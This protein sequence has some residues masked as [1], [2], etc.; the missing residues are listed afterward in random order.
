MTSEK[1]R[2]EFQWQGLGVEVL[3]CP[4]WFPFYEEIYGYPLAHLEIKTIQ[5]EGAPL[6]ITETGYLSHFMRADAID[7]EGGPLAYARTWLD[8][9]AQ[10]PAWKEQQAGQRQY[11]LF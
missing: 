5:P 7:A 8:H 9:A 2:F 4:N 11:S 1:Q 6:P 3:Y 10:S